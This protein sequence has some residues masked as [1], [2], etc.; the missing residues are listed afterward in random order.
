MKATATLE[1]WEGLATQAR[2]T[3]AGEQVLK[4][5]EDR[6]EG[7]I[8]HTDAKVRYFGKDRS[9][10]RVKI[11]RDQAAWCPYC[12]KVWLL[13]EEKQVDYEVEKVPMRSYGDKPRSSWLWFLAGFCQP[14][15]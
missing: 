9:K 8:P 3:K 10:P 5:W 11:Y 13:L 6:A 7:L 4:S 15:K 2:Q 1:S 12:Q 14:W